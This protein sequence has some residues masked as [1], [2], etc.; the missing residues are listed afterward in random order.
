MYITPTNSVRVCVIDLPAEMKYY[1]TR[2]YNFVVLN[3]LY[4][5][6][7]STVQGARYLVPGTVRYLAYHQCDN[8]SIV[9]LSFSIW[10]KLVWKVFSLRR[11]FT[12]E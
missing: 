3:L 7:V 5:Y 4:Q 10:P 12:A 9:L 1:C 8:A 2:N 6:I 11:F